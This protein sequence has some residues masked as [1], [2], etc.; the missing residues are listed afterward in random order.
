MTDNDAGTAADEPRTPDPIRV[1]DFDTAGPIELDIGNTIG[2]VDI[3]LTDT[4]T[5]SVEVRHDPTAGY[6]DWRGGL[7]GL[8]S[9][10]T[11]QFG[12]SGLRPGRADRPNFD[13]RNSDVWRERSRVPREPIA[14][15]VREA[16][17]DLTGN[18][19]VV[20]T[21]DGVP[22]R[23][24][25]LSIK[26][27]APA[28]SQVG[29]RTGAGAI[30][31]TG[32]AGR[33]QVQSGAGAV[34][35]ERVSGP[36]NVRTGS[37]QLRLGGMASGVQARSGSGDVEIASVEA[38]SSI[39]TGSGNVWLGAVSADVLVRSGSGDVTIADAVAGRS[40][41]V[42]GSGELQISVHKGV[43]AEVDLTSSTG[44]ARSELDVTGD[45]PEHEPALWIFART[46]SGDALL[47]TAV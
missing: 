35:A 17:V 37:G 33:L 46:G 41:L 26:V 14:D 21:P 1:Q 25:P 44:V 2:P 32:T 39:V 6:L 7:S 10:V 23:T 36:A 31:I 3:E 15:A 29:V 4:A 28:E 42:T 24:V 20:R 40:E 12:E 19:L 5:T 9:W 27:V 13:W 11:E 8:L 45:P 22:L 38:A 43:S 16:R 47:S 34:S 30:R 18:R